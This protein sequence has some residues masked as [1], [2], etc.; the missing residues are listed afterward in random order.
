MKNINIA[1]TNNH[2]KATISGLTILDNLAKVDEGKFALIH[3]ETVLEV[4]K[5]L[6]NCDNDENVVQ[7]AAKIFSKIVNLSVFGFS[8]KNSHPTS[9]LLLGA[10]SPKI[11]LPFPSTSDEKKPTGL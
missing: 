6:E 8:T 11:G 10:A 1:C 7:V 4:S 2:I 3:N 9:I 5:V